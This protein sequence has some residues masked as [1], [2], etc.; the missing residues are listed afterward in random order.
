MTDII[1]M[2][3]QAFT[4][5]QKTYGELD[6]RSFTVGYCLGLQYGANFALKQLSALQANLELSKIGRDT[7]EQR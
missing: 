5:A 3:E 6:E 4:E 2:T 1:K 7:H